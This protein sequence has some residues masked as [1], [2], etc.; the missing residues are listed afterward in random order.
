MDLTRKHAEESQRVRSENQESVYIGLNRLKEL[1]KLNQRPKTIECFDIAIWQGKSPTASQ[2][3][4]YE[5]MADKKSYRY[6]HL[7]E[8]PEGNNDFAMMKEVFLRRLKYKNFP[9]VF[10]VDGG[11]AQ[12]NTVIEILRELEVDVPVVGIAKARDLDSGN[13]HVKDI[14]KTEERLIIPGR[15]NPYILNKCQ[16]LFR[17]MVQM[18]DEAHR[19]SRKLH[20]KAE[21]DRLFQ[22]K[23]KKR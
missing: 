6:Y 19:F 2:V 22:G 11:R 12:V 8:R 16:S 15:A 9:D 4:F 18:R 1:L 23:N 10:L 14:R 17:I 20:H 5:G 21:E 7:E 13:L 3:V